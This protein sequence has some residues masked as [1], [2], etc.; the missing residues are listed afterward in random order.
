MD[1]YPHYLETQIPPK[2][3]GF[4]PRVHLSILSDEG[5]RKHHQTSK[6]LNPKNIGKCHELQAYPDHFKKSSYF[7]LDK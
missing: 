4:V 7:I 5:R 6:T 3:L 1:F 2:N